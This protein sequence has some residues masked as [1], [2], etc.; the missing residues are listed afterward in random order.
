V[1]YLITGSPEPEVA[2]AI[3]ASIETLLAQSQA[4]SFPQVSAW[5]RA[6]LRDNVRS[7]TTGQ[8]GATW[9]TTPPGP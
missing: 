3:V 4:P 7:R 2:A 5:R 6:A 1:S 8:P 9:R